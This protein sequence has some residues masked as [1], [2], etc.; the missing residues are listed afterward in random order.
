MNSDDFYRDDSEYDDDEYVHKNRHK[1]QQKRKNKRPRQDPSQAIQEI[2]DVSGLEGGFTTTYQPARFEGE[3]LID[4]LR[5]F[6]DQHLISDILAQIKGGKE[7]SV[8]RCTANPATGFTLLAAKVYRP[9]M[10]RNLRND[11]MYQQGREVLTPD[12]RPVKKTDHRLMR[13][14]GKRTSFGEQ[15]KHTSWLMHEFTTLERLHQ[16]GAAVPQPFA[17]SENAILMGYHGD[18]RTAAPTLHEIRLDADEAEPLFHETLRN[19]ELMLQHQM[20]H[21]DLSAYNILYW[22]GHITLIDFP[23]VVNSHSNRDAYPILQRDVKRVC[24]YF[25][26]YGIECDAVALTDELWERY[27][28][29]VEEDPIELDDLDE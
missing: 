8:Y 24:Q 5:E 23:Q 26:H 15:V 12:G 4:S 2:A 25:A 17:T 3:W 14:L 28:G 29:F 19:I 9:K 7:A 1:A 6:Y 22:E 21:G 20:I 10:F 11:A 16:A 13:A 27:V 18:E